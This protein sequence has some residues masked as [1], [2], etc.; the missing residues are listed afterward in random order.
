MGAV[1]LL[2]GSPPGGLLETEARHIPGKQTCS[3]GQT[4]FLTP[5]LFSHLLSSPL[6]PPPPDRHCLLHAVQC[7]R[8][9]AW[10]LP[11]A[12]LELSEVSVLA[13]TSQMQKLRPREVKE[14]VHMKSSHKNQGWS[15]DPGGCKRCAVDCTILS[16]AHTHP[17]RSHVRALWVKAI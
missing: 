6:S 17:Y 1:V 5:L 15:L 7:A 14:Y 11:P 12:P 2:R 3:P 10:G 9:H 16:P 4:L 8:N 13:P